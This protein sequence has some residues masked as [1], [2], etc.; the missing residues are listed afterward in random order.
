MPQ[1][2]M[3]IRR[4]STFLLSKAVLAVHVGGLG[5]PGGTC[6]ARLSRLYLLSDDSTPPPLDVPVSLTA[7]RGL[8]SRPL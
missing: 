3:V 6:A 5:G 2:S 8:K 7:S 4:I 1:G